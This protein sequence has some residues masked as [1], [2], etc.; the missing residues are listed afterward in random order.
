M[1]QLECDSAHFMYQQDGAPPHLYNEDR[2]FLNDPLPNTWIGRAGRDDMQIL[3]W[4]SRSPDLTPCDFYLWAYVKDSVFVPSLPEN[5]PELRA[6]IINTIAAIDMDT[7]SHLELAAS[8]PTAFTC[9]SHRTADERVFSTPPALLN[10]KAPFNVQTYTFRHFFFVLS[11]D[12]LDR[13]PLLSREEYNACSSVLCNFL[14]SPVTSSLLAPNIFLST[15]FS[16]TLNLCSS[17]RSF[18]T[19]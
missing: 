14:H 15:L 4:P 16:N 12:Q 19:E 9:L 13:I 11:C 2:T 8:L 18:S 5:L 10:D 6:R 1:P 17:L 3:S 7:H